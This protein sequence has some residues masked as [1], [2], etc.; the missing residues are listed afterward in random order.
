MLF[1]DRASINDGTS[2]TEAVEWYT[3]AN[4]ALLNHLTKEIKDTDSSTIW[5][6]VLFFLF[7]LS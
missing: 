3:N 2:M 4:A 6:S 1:L 5:R 7:V